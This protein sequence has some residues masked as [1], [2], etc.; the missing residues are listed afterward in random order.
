MMIA[1]HGGRLVNRI[2]P[3]EELANACQ[4]AGDL[5]KLF[6]NWGIANDVRNIAQGVFSP[7]EGF[8]TSQDF[9][10]II[11]NDQLTSGVAWTIPVILDISERDIV[12]E[13]QMVCLMEEGGSHPLAIMEVAD[14][15]CWDKQAAAE[16]IFGTTDTQHP[17]VRRLYERGDYLVGGKIRLLDN[18][19]GPYAKFNLPPAETRAIFA[20]R[21]WQTICAFQ[22]RNV[23]HR[24]HEELQKT[25]LGLVDGLLVQPVIGKKK[26]GD[27]RD[28]VILDTYQVLIDDY[29]PPDRV[30][31]NIL[32]FEMR[33]AGPKEAI[34]HAIMRKNYGCTHIIIGR[35]HAGVGD[36]YGEE[37][38]IEIFEQPQ[39]A[40]LQIQPITIRGDFWYCTTCQ[41]VASDR[42]CPHGPDAQISFSG[43]NIRQLIAQ[44]Q[45]PPPEVMRPEVFEVIQKSDQPFVE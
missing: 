23:P 14:V 19:P 11:E 4:Q 44:G 9:G 16:A 45:A 24:G 10:S 21:G 31:L 32:P 1:P 40:D 25:V 37:D 33:Y 26:P 12:R 7:L 30:V 34:M 18:D 41:R 20:Q 43:T 2:V 39:F 8:V 13:G 15:Y 27:Y 6:V 38:A 29:Y 42:T 28:E 35:D 36:Y 3:Q 17:G 22:T 5:P